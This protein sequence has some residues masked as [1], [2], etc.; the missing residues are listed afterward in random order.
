MNMKKALAAVLAVVI[1]ISAMAIGVFAEEKII[2]LHPGD[3][4]KTTNTVVYSFDFPVAALYGYTNSA[5]YLE[6]NLPT[7]LSVAGKAH[8]IAWAIEVN[9]NTYALKGTTATADSYVVDTQY[10]NFGYLAHSYLNDTVWTTI[11]QSGM[12][13]DTTSVKLTATVVL[14]TNEKDDQVLPITHNTKADLLDTYGLGLAEEMSV[15]MWE[16]VGTKDYDTWSDDI[17]V[18]GSWLPVNVMNPVRATAAKTEVDYAA[19]L[20]ITTSKDTS[21]ALV[22]DHNLEHKAWINGATSAQVVVETREAIKG[23]GIYY[24]YAAKQEG[25]SYDTW[26][27]N[28][29]NS[30][31]NAPATDYKWVT[32]TVVNGTTSTLVF[33]ITLADLY[34]T[35]YGIYNHGFKV[36]Y[37]GVQGDSTWSTL[38]DTNYAPAVKSAYILLQMPEEVETPD[39]EVE[40]PAESGDAGSDD[41]EVDENPETGLVLSVFAMIAAAAAVVI[42]KR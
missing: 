22:W 10:V 29:G 39:I 40:E 2:P 38:K 8:N 26:Q 5:N 24:L 15:Q 20:F 9:G 12:V 25:N 34:D 4:T 13:G 27:S 3:G 11:P 36:A 42:C 1:A 6:L 16:A 30:F 35:V 18:N 33:D 41:V 31:W 37:Y 14:A 19:N 32:E 7:N 28:G 21:P 17:K 23:L